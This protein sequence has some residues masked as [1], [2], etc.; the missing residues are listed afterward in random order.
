MDSHLCF[1]CVSDNIW[2]LYNIMSLSASLCFLDLSLLFNNQLLRTCKS[3]TFGKQ[4]L[5]R[6]CEI[7]I[8]VSCNV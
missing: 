1:D 2:D 6:Y 5:Y 8:G 4:T 3:T 7:N